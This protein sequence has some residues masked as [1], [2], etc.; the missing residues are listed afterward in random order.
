M[1]P[2]GKPTRHEDGYAKGRYAYDD[3][4]YRIETAYYDERD[5]PTLHKDGC[6]KVRNK[7]NDKGQLIEWACFGL[8]GSPIVAKKYG[9][10]KARVTYDAH[11]K[12]SR[13]D[14]FDP[15]DHLMRSAYGYATVRYSYDEIGRETKREFFDANGAPVSTRVGIDKVEPGSKSERIGLRVGD[16]IVAYDGREVADTRVFEELEL[17]IGERPR[18]LTIHREGRVLSLDVSAGRLTGIE[19]VDNTRV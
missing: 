7:Y 4:G 1:D 2:E 12:R 13:V 14:Y 10:A 9:R 8:D 18:Q 5:L 3:R 6:A 19:T 11:G 16:L 17:V 15:N